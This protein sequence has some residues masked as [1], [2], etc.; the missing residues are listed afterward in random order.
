[1]IVL[2]TSHYLKSKI[3][4][5]IIVNTDAYLQRIILILFRFSETR[6]IPILYGSLL[7][8]SYDFPL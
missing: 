3:T 1:M 5:D 7:K 4:D 8:I 6:L 2:E